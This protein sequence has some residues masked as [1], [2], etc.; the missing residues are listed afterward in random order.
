MVGAHDAA[1]DALGALRLAARLAGL[2][3]QAGGYKLATLHN[4]QTTW[5]RS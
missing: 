4:H 5:A 3:R 2:W 1:A